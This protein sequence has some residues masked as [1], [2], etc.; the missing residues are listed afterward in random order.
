[1]VGKFLQA[2][3]E[4]LGMQIIFVTHHHPLQAFADRVYHTSEKD[5]KS[6]VGVA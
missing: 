5:G 6:E 1:L 3:T 4:Q 2:L